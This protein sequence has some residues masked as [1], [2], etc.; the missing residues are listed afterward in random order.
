MTD[1]RARAL[2]IYQ[3]AVG[4]KYPIR[5]TTSRGDFS[6]REHAIEAFNVPV[7]EQRNIL[8]SIAPVREEADRLAGGRC[9]FIMHTPEA[10]REHYA[11]LL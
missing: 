8:R 6:G 1:D 10:T 11:H 3:T 7:R 9:L 5:W 2:Q 4:P